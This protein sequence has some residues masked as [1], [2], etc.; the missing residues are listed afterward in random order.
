MISATINP[1]SI[2]GIGLRLPGASTP[3]ELWSLLLDGRS[4]VSDTAVANRWRPERFL[5][6]DK[7]ARGMTYTFAGGYLTDGLAFDPAAFG[8]SP[9]EAAQMDP[10]QRVILEV[11]WQALEDA[12]IPPSEIAGENVGVYVGASVVDHANAP[13]LDLAAIDSHFMTGNSLSIVSNRLSYAFNLKGPSLSIDTAC[14]SSIVA[15]AEA[16][17]ALDQGRIEL[18]I[19]GGVNMLMSPAPFVGFSRAGMLSPTGRCRPFSALG[20][21]YVRSEGCVALVLAR[22][23]SRFERLSPRAILRAIGVNSDG[24]TAG[25]SLPSFEGQSLLLQQLY[26]KAGISPEALAFVEAHGTGT[27]VGDPIEARALGQAL[28]QA[29]SSPLPIGSIKSN[30][31]HLESASGLAGLTKAVLSLEHRTCP[32]TL[33]LDELNPD[34]DTARLN[35]KPAAEAVELTGSGQLIAGLGNYGFGGTNAHA[36]LQA[37]P[38][39]EVVPMSARQA[40]RHLVISAHSKVALSALAK[41]YIQPV[42]LD[43]AAVVAGAIARTRDTLPHRL[44]IDL[45]AEPDVIEALRSPFTYALSPGIATGEAVAPKARIAFVFSGNGSQWPGMGRAI[46][47]TNAIFKAHFDDMAARIRSVGGICPL[48][49]MNAD[50]VEERLKATSAVQPLLFSIQVA[51]SAALAEEGLKPALVFGHSVGE[52]AAA[53]VS[54]ALSLDDA[55]FLIVQRS[56]HQEFVRGLGRMLVLGCDVATAQ[57]LIDSA[58]ANAVE[59]AAS[60]APT[61]TTLSGSQAA[62]SAISQLARGRRVPALVLDIDYP[63]HSKALDP[64]QD[65]T[66]V[67][68]ARLRAGPCRIPMISSVTAQHVRGPELD[69]GYWWANIRDRVLFQAATEMAASEADLFIEI[70]PRPI[71]GTSI[72]ETV[73]AIGGRA[74]TVATLT[75]TKSD[76]GVDP[77]MRIVV[78]AIA[79]GAVLDKEPPDADLERRFLPHMRWNHLDCV[80]NTTPESYNIYGRVWT[81]EAIHLLTGPKVAP[82]GHE[83]RQIISIETH[84]FLAGHKVGDDVI[85]P[86]TAYIEMIFAVGRDVHKTSRLQI[87]DLDITRAM[88][89]EPQQ[90]REVAIVWSALDRTVEVRSRQRFDADDTFT[91]HAKAVVLP[92]LSDLPQAL[93]KPAAATRVS[94]LDTYQATAKCQLNYQGAFR[95]VAHCDVSQ[96]AVEMT[97]VPVLSDLGAYPDTM[98]IDPASYDASFH[99]LF[100]GVKHLPGQVAGELPVRI[101]KIS[102]LQPGVPICG[103]RA[104]LRRQTREARVFDVDILGSD[105]TVVARIQGLV[106]RRVIHASWSEAERT[107]FVRHIPSS[108]DASV[109]PELVQS[110]LKQ[111]APPDLNTEARAALA[112]LALDGAA[113][114]LSSILGAQIPKERLSRHAD[115]FT[116]ENTI[117]QTLLNALTEAGRTQDLADH[118]AIEVPEQSL[119]A[120]LNSFAGRHPGASA[121]LRL[122]S[123]SFRAL[124]Y[125]LRS[126]AALPLPVELGD[127][128]ASGSLFAAPVLDGLAAVVRNICNRSPGRKLRLLLLEPGFM[129]LVPR[130]LPLAQR[131]SLSLTLLVADDEDLV[132]KLS[133]IEARD[134]VSVL[135]PDMVDGVSVFDLVLCAAVQPLDFGSPTPLDLWKSLGAN[136]APMLIGVPEYDPAIDVFNAATPAWFALSQSSDAPVGLWPFPS[137]TEQSLSSRGVS[138]IAQ[139]EA[140]PGGARL[141]FASFARRQPVTKRLPTP[142]VCVHAEP[143]TEDAVQRWLPGLKVRVASTLADVVSSLADLVGARPFAIAIDR[144]KLISINEAEALAASMLRLKDLA[145][146]LSQT[147]TP[148][149]LYVVLDQNVIAP[150]EGLA[151]QTA[152][153]GFVRCLINEYPAINVTL[154]TL[155]D[156]VDEA[157]IGKALLSHIDKPL[158]EREIILSVDGELLPRAH[159]NISSVLEPVSDLRGSR[160]TFGARGL[161]EPLWPLIPRPAPSSDEVEVEVAATGLNFRDVMLGLGVL[162]DE[163]LGEGLTSGSLGFEFSG[164]I[165]KVGE[166]V[167]DLRVGD[168]VIG[169]GSNAFSSHLTLPR[170]NVF[171]IGN[172]LSLEAAATIPVAFVTAWYS[173]VERARLKPGE[174]VLIQGAAGGVGLA[175]LQIAKSI[176]ARVVAAAGTSEKRALLLQL[177]ADH[178]VDSRATAF[179]EAVRSCVNGVDV[180]LNSVAGDA[181]QATLRLVKP[182]G[183]F[184]ELGKRDFLD[185]ARIG[186][187]PFVKNISYIGVDLD[188]LL[189]HDPA[190]VRVIVKTILQRVEAGAFTPLLHTTFESESLAHAFR[191]MQSSGHVGKIVV[192]PA[193]AGI[194]PAPQTPAFNPE[195]GAHIVLG[196]TAGF[197]LTT[198]LWLAECGAKTVVVVSRRGEIS[199]DRQEDV[200]AFRELGVTFLAEALDITNPQDVASAFARWRHQH[201][202]IAGV[203]HCAMVLE[204]GLIE[205]LTVDS[206]AKVLAPKVTGMRATADAVAHDRLQYFV[207]F[208]SATTLVGSPGQ[209]SYVAGNAFLEGAVQ[210]MRDRGVPALAV[211]WGAISDVGVVARTKGLAERLRATTGVSGVKSA[212]AL[213]YLGTLLADPLRSPPVSSYSVIR[214]S[215]AASK[216]AVLAA[217]YFAEV[218][219]EVSRNTQSSGG[220]ALDIASLEPEAARAALQRLICDEV[221]RI[222]RLPDADIDPARPLIDIGLDSLMA[223]ELRLGIEKRTG[224][225]LPVMSLSGGRSVTDLVERVVSAA[226]QPTPPG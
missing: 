135:K 204:D 77:V 170:A 193:L 156:G 92:E 167:R 17:A 136:A 27:R 38:R 210:A 74:A 202:T 10:Q 80:F 139:S 5:S 121:D 213:T 155:Q 63:F 157:L 41:A 62:I 35:I 42:Q 163:I 216:L 161:D 148:V 166:A 132:R 147:T 40:P 134:F 66:L 181:M 159:R 115:H 72:A 225:E 48:A 180:V 146:A 143:G 226:L 52:V 199:P 194:S 164:H 203:T 91:I 217:P 189:A 160:L 129:G 187:R 130:L 197:G 84:P 101:S 158:V 60:N 34:I 83:W 221:A 53:T 200:E 21:G 142:S 39:R 118:V 36:I 102:L 73:R 24:R 150:D 174:T 59:I 71:L 151:V 88:A 172:G 186:L 75:S 49:T 86:A 114:V 6:T 67:G 182:F 28:G 56:G 120:C 175:A 185:N 104:V 113:H 140:L 98:V 152:L 137:E 31:G 179:E 30:I 93:A 103:S 211:S 126:G 26:D 54:G 112:K 209:A 128:I 111:T 3:E 55:A 205:G 89:L 16:A 201:G 108:E 14:S 96:D 50:D 106:M 20:D 13:L 22:P 153:S 9:R 18:A 82:G 11:V 123:H 117:V 138:L 169:F 4:S 109:I 208:S 105:Q 223:L 25:I 177:G 58:R 69:A 168:R 68:L 116:D 220:D 97:L 176:G 124:D 206:I 165:V 87:L 191:L 1:T 184:I 37:A 12:G 192:R 44:V 65:S 188:Q 178:V 64:E 57:G 79:A 131:G 51:L 81:R 76:S 207:A 183:R 154:L 218:F 95:V 61:S 29:R 196:G 127:A 15:L 122:A 212:E 195:A 47:A 85:V 145:S 94:G 214:W 70:G 45:K 46:Y 23:G 144:M 119:Q 32:K 215:P 99:G 19:V 78:D 7:T 149:R 173:L 2:L 162:D 222:L 43:G 133:R 190:E 90:G 107:V 224:I 8:L 219:A 171:K 125:R 33:Y 100:L 198:A 110:A 141:M